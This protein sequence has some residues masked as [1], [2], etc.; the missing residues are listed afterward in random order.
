MVL[1]YALSPIHTSMFG[2]LQDTNGGG[3]PPHMYTGV[4]K[5]PD[6]VIVRARALSLSHSTFQCVLTCAL[7]MT[8]SHHIPHLVDLLFFF[9]GFTLRFFVHLRL[10]FRG[11][12]RQN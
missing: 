1:N 10:S 6:R 7:P 4:T 8:S 2:Q 9:V 5:Y 12:Y 11:M 3:A